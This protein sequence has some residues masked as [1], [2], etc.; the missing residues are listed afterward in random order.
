MKNRD[1][2]SWDDLRIAVATTRTGSLSGA[3]R[4]CGLSVATVGRRL[5]RLERTLG[6][7][8]FHR[9]AGGV[10]A[11]SDASTLLARAEE[12][13]DS[14]D[15]IRRIAA[16]GAS[17]AEGEVTLTTL[18]TIITHA[19]AP[20]L[21]ELREAHP[22]I[23]LVLRPSPRIE[24]LDLRRA[25]IA[26]RMVR[27]HEPRVVGRKLGSQR[28]AVFASPAYLERFGAPA[29]PEQ[30]LRGHDVVMF[31]GRAD[32]AE[33]AWLAART[34]EP[35][36]FRV[37]TITAT[38]ALVRGGAAIGVLPTVLAT[39]D[40]V[41]LATSVPPRE[42]WLVLHENLRTA[43]AIRAVA[44]FLVDVFRDALEP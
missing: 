17:E 39:P 36:A 44:D 7:T 20:R 12:V 1:D 14:V 18:E 29:D 25:D 28:M 23:R 43:P 34:D 9:H 6:K 37:S 24:R 33:M 21:A 5:D 19:V 27:P 16:A 32:G 10:L 2:L 41:T 30:D 38:A 13:A 26:V 31:D 3:A 15:E 40:L 8:L 11:S 22:R 42:L 35:P 4:R